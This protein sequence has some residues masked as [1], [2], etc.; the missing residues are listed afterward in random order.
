[1]YVYALFVCLTTLSYA[2]PTVSAGDNFSS[3][4]NQSV[5]TNRELNLFQRLQQATFETDAE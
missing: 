1:M 4:I 3:I 2:V 5:N